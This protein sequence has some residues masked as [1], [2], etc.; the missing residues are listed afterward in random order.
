[1]L[2]KCGCGL[3]ASKNK[4]FKRNHKKN[5][6]LVSQLCA[7]G[8]KKLAKSGNKFIHGHNGKFFYVINQEVQDGIRVAGMKGK[9]HTKES[10]RKS[11]LAHKGQKAWNKGKVGV[12]VAWNKG[13]TKETNKS[14]AKYVNSHKGYKHTEEAKEKIRE[15]RLQQ[16][17]PLKDTSIEVKLQNGLT[18]CKILYSKHYPF[19]KEIATQIDIAI[20]ERKIAIYC[21][22]D[23]WHNLPNYII[24]DS[25]ANEILVKHGWIVLRFWEHE[26][27]NDLDNCLKIILSNLIYSIVKSKKLEKISDVLCR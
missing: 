23:Y 17:M 5:L 4:G 3:E 15:K 2:C 13:A 24:R 16:I 10:K 1:M 25:K 7:C 6:K 8:C 18:N 14:V 20:P 19:H 22:G 26:I 27:H 9:H 12:Q 11:S 21:D